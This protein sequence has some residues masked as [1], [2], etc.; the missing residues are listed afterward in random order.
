VVAIISF[1]T[2]S[3]FLGLF[4]TAVMSMMTCLA[5]DMDNH[6]GTPVK[7]PKTFHDCLSN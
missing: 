5:I 7:G 6:N 3:I 4:D 2:A 1:L